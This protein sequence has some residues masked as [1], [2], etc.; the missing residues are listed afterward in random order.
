LD[1]KRDRE[2][3][4]FQRI[5]RIN[6]TKRCPGL[7][8]ESY[9]SER[10]RQSGKVGKE[11]AKGENLWTRAKRRYEDGEWSE[12]ESHYSDALRTRGMGC[13]YKRVQLLYVR[14]ESRQRMLASSEKKEHST[15]HRIYYGG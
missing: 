15:R 9:F 13:H 12:Q 2:L 8:F 10:L 14:E 5:Q 6:L 11:M 4:A 1:H 7:T 3:E